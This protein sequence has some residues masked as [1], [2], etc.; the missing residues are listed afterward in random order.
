MDTQSRKPSFTLS[1]LTFIGI[2]AIIGFG[3]IGLKLDAHVPIACAACFAA[4]VGKYVVGIGWGEMEETVFATITSSMSALLILF[5][6]GMLIG[7]WMLSGVVPG[8][9]YY[10]L[11]LLTP[12]SFLLATLLLCSIVSVATGSSWGVGGT[13]GVALIGIAAGLGI[14][15]PLTAGVI[16]SGAYFGDKMSPLSDTTNLAPAVSGSNLYDHI[17]AMMWTTT[18]SYLIVMAIVVYLGNRYGG[19]SAAFDPS[20]IEA[21]QSL[22]L[23]EFTIN[24]YYTAIPPLVV[25][26]LAL[27]KYPAIPGMIAGTAAASILSLIQGRSL[28]DVLNAIHYGYTSTVATQVSKVSLEGVP[29]L[30]GKLNITNVVPEAAHEAGKLLTSL[31][32]RGGISS[33]MWSLSLIIIALVLGG[34]MERCAF[35]ETI[36]SPLLKKVKTVGGFVALVMGSCFA[37]NFFL[38]DQY[39]GIVV[40]GR[41]FKGAVDKTDLSPRM[42][43]RTLEDC[44]TMT[45]V[46]IPWTGCGA[47]Q[48]SALGVP[49]LTYL[50]YCFLNYINPIVAL[51]MTYMGIG[52]Y[53]GKDKAD[54]V[55]R[56]TALS[57]EA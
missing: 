32:N 14:P 51:I 37:G 13:V 36:L 12:G 31:L 29:E 52:I 41:M 22:M 45:A 44:A 35:L 33:M 24:P 2:A 55:E 16:I 39:L 46:L 48:A 10:G 8:M 21:M 11:N 57:F 49:T 17:R 6:I 9:I 47:F 28:H 50:P 30:L 26:I 19:G 38:G 54:K 3:L 4:L 53:W 7:S 40:P 25:L 27:I 5:T 34:I 1:L 15:A 42:L 56:R 43:S 18:P 23:Q 20:R